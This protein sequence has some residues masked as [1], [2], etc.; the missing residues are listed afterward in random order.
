MGISSFIFEIR[1][2]LEK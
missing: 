2:G 1:L